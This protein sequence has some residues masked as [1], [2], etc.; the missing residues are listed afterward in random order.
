MA[1]EKVFIEGIGLRPSTQLVWDGTQLTAV[2]TTFQATS[3]STVPLTA[4]G[5]TSQTASLQEWKNSSDTVLSKIK[6][7]GVLSLVSFTVATLPTGALGD[8]C[9]V[10]DALLPAF[11]SAVTGGGAVKCP[12]FHNGSVWIVG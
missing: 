8:R 1:V 4:K 10:T 12:V 7:S 2:K 3:A 11:L 9:F 5:A 6:S